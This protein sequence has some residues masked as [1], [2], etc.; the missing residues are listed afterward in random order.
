MVVRVLVE[1]C[2]QVVSWDPFLEAVLFGFIRT[3]RVEK[4]VMV[5]LRA[6]SI[7]V[8]VHDDSQ[9]PL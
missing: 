5:E 7:V 1:G 2:L 3:P 8:R 9:E 6:F 4:H